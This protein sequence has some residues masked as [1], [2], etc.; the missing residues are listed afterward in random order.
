MSTAT[1][2]LDKD[3]NKY[4][5]GL[6]KKGWSFTRGGKHACLISP[7]DRKFPVPGSPSDSRSFYNFKHRMEK[8]IRR[9]TTREDDGFMQ[10][11]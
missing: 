2:S 6:I 5:K 1:Y 10:V 11:D 9:Y 7:G 8:E 4:V 3:I